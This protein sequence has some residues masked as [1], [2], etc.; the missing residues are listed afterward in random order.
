MTCGLLL[1]W[2]RDFTDGLKD[3]HLEERCVRTSVITEELVQKVDE[4]VKL[5]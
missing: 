1:R 4:Q 3:V 2:I 5:D